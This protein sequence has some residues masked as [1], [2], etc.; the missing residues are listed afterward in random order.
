[1]IKT[2]QVEEKRCVC[3]ICNNN[4]YTMHSPYD[5]NRENSWIHVDN[6]ATT[7]KTLDICPGCVEFLRSALDGDNNG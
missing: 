4:H 7:G 2:V 6:F 5:I 3:D 1:M